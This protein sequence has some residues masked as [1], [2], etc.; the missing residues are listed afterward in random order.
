MSR[1]GWYWLK[2]SD[3]ATRGWHCFDVE[4][5]DI[6]LQERN[7]DDPYPPNYPGPFRPTI[8]IHSELKYED[9]RTWPTLARAK[10]AATKALVSF[11]RSELEKTRRAIGGRR[12]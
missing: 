2:S 9:K 5:Y 10:K 7:G 12:K 6:T 4:D 11:L 3:D 1:Y 8:A